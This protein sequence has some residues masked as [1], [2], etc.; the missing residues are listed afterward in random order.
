MAYFAIKQLFEIANKGKRL[1]IFTYFYK[2]HP[3][4]TKNALIAIFILP[5]IL[6]QFLYKDGNTWK[7]WTQGRSSLMIFSKEPFKVYG[8]FTTEQ[9]EAAD[10]L[11]KNTSKNEKIMADGYS[12]EALDFF[13]V[14]DYDIPLFHPKESVHI[15]PDSTKK[16]K[17]NI[18]PIYLFTYSSFD[19]GPEKY[20]SFYPIFEEEIV[21]ALKKENFDYL[22][23]SGR[24]LFFKAYFD[25]A[26]WARLRFTNQSIRI[27]EIHLERMEPV[28]FENIGVN[29]AINRHLIWLEKN[30]PDEY[31]LFKEKIEILGLTFDELKNSQLRFPK[32][33][34]Y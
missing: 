20:R 31:S 6:Y 1:K 12:H 22:V 19:S 9:Q 33:Q 34:I 8:R 32:E 18:R 16:R 10:W 11:K 29:D 26:K 13:G 23:I 2:K 7:V 21:N 28:V 30:C 17:D 24:G 3:A 5:L 25:K 27:Y 15:T 14:A 4:L